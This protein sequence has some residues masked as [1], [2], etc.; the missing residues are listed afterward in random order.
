MA[1]TTIDLR[2]NVIGGAVGNVM[3][4]YDFA[5]YAYMAPI[6]GKLFFPSEDA[7][8]SLIAAFGA[9]AAGYVSRPL[10]A[11]LFGHIG[12]KIGR[13]PMLLIS[14]LMMGLA[15][16]A[17]GLLPVESQIGWVAAAGL[18]GLRLIQGISVGGEYGGSLAFV[19]EHAPPKRRGFAISFIMVGANLGFLV[20]AGTAALVT[21]SFN[22][23]ELNAWAWRVPFLLGG[24][25]A[26]IALLLRRSLS[27]PP[28]P[29]GYEP[30]VGSPVIVAF[31]DHWRD[32]LK[33]GGLYLAVNAGFYL[34]FVYVVSY[35]TTVMHMPRDAAMD[36]NVACILIMCVLPVGFAI[37]SDRIGRKPMLIAGGIGI[38]VL[39]YPLF[40]LIDNSAVLPV[41][42]G[43]IGFAV[44][45]SWI[46]GAN[47]A[48]QTEVAPRH[49]RATVLTMSTNIAMA[50]FGGTMPMVAAYLVHRTHDDY[51][52]A[53]YL[54]GLGV[55]SLIAVFTT[56]EMA[57]K[58]LP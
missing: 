16:T 17:I 31:R 48:A 15:T 47:P 5:A 37:L 22:D 36:I 53:Y 56:R 18:V 49:V 2:R 34:I 8:A 6:L 45:F 55:L 3:E 28:V 7:F 51:S 23:A 50:V 44:L 38:I 21:E 58:R 40:M 30:T 4:W 9:F 41:L 25:I 26:L 29:L 57:G 10:G 42:L 43:Q 33:V 14:V 12:D 13:K 35:L 54:M 20:G 52:P 32:M 46:Y 39:T 11:I 1:A 27:E 19:A 24:V